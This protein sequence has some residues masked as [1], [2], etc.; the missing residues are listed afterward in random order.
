MVA[1]LE[2]KLTSLEDELEQMKMT[3]E[4]NDTELKVPRC[5]G[6]GMRGKHV[7]VHWLLA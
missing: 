3:V 2:S 6:N 5:H 1:E 4:Q 7:A